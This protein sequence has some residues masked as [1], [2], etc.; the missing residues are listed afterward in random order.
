MVRVLSGSNDGT[1]R[2]R[3]I[4]NGEPIL[5]PIKT[6]Y[7]EVQAVVYS[8]DMTIFASGGLDGYLTNQSECSVKIWDANTGELVA[9]VKGHRSPVQCLARV[10][11][12][13][14]KLTI[15]EIKSRKLRQAVEQNMP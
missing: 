1:A 4:E 8:P 15:N 2:Q 14:G 9:A 5:T 6:G 11:V 7:E 10:S 13:T 3:D 12:V